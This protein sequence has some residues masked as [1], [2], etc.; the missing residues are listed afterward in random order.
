MTSNHYEVFAIKYAELKRDARSNFV[1][2]DVH[3]TSDMPLDYFVWVARNDQRSIVID[4]GF[5]EVI[6]TRRGRTITKSVENGLTAIGVDP[7]TVRDVVISHMHYDHCGNEDLFP[8]AR[9]HLQDAEMEYAT[10]RSMCH[11]GV[12]HAFEADDVARMVHRV[13]DGRVAFHDGDEELAPGIT[14]HRLGGHTKGLQVVRVETANGPT[15]LASDAS[16]F[17]A[18]FEQLRVFPVLYN[19]ADVIEG[20]QTL[21]KLAGAGRRIIPGHDPLVLDR[22]PA[23]SEATAGWIAR[24]DLNLD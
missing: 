23:A 19:L 7:T 10:G 12:A 15:V 18:H 17:Y 5:S 20:Y 11:H 8:A 1:D 22:Y 3:E 9:Y 21:T 13:F 6:G 14:L 16:H 24:L 2:G 4:T